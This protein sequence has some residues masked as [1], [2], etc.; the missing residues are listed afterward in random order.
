MPT[1]ARIARTKVGCRDLC[2]WWGRTAWPF[3]TTMATACL[4]ASVTCL[5]TQP[6]E[7]CSSISRVRAVA[8]EWTREYQRRRP[9]PVPVRGGQ[10]DRPRQGRS[11][12]SELS[13]LYS[14]DA[15]RGAVGIR[16]VQRTWAAGTRLEEG[17]PVSGSLAARL[18]LVGMPSLAEAVLTHRTAILA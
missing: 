9:A 10:A 1:A 3:P 8:R 5:P 16:P 18:N 11:H 14:Q 7:S 2:R 6:S 13:A 15:D 4:K 12:F 17:T